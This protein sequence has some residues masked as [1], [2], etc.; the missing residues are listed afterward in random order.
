MNRTIAGKVEMI[1]ELLGGQPIL[2]EDGNDTGEVTA[3]IITKEDAL[4]L[5]NGEDLQ[6]KP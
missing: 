1:M 2:D 6:E 4:K 5:L 3:S